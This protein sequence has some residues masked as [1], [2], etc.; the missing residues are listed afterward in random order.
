MPKEIPG[1]CG[2]GSGSHSQELPGTTL[3][4]F[5]IRGGYQVNG[6]GILCQG[7]AAPRLEHL[8]LIRTTPPIA[9]GVWERRARRR[10]FPI[11]CFAGTRP[12]SAA[13]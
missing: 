1:R 6:G 11:A 2:A 5:T 3:R 7:G 4:G 8:V 10:R 12:R 9:E 13:A